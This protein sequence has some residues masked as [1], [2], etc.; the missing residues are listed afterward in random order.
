MAIFEVFGCFGIVKCQTG[1]FKQLVVMYLNEIYPTVPHLSRS[2]LAFRFY[3][4]KTVKNSHYIWDAHQHFNHKRPYISK[5]QKV[6]VVGFWKVF[7]CDSSLWFSLET[8]LFQKLFLL[9][10]HLGPK[11]SC[12]ARA[13]MVDPRLKMHYAPGLVSIPK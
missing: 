10:G 7:N 4:P 3:D 13:R 9:S 2:D 6:V 5:L 12:N 8:A 1:C 11:G